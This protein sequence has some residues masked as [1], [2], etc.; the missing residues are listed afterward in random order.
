MA[1]YSYVVRGHTSKIAFHSIQ[2]ALQHAS[3]YV[4]DEYYLCE[5]PA[6]VDLY[7][8]TDTDDKDGTYVGWEGVADGLPW[9]EG[10]ECPNASEHPED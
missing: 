4:Q 5:L 10:D 1:L 8:H 2:A 9:C 7:K 3:E 6:A